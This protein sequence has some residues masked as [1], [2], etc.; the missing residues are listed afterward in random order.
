MDTRPAAQHD[1]CALQQRI[2][3]S[4]N[5]DTENPSLQWGKVSAAHLRVSP[6]SPLSSLS[7]ASAA[8]LRVLHSATCSAER[9]PALSVPRFLALSSLLSLCRMHTVHH[10]VHCTELNSTLYT[11]H[12]TLYSVQCTVY[13]T[14]YITLHTAHCTL[15]T[16]STL[17][18]CTL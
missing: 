9:N 16:Y 15:Y 2:L 3:L 6:L 14:L 12:F 4:D 13:T 1:E 7:K 5:K 10:T 17:L 18:R 11:V 8:H